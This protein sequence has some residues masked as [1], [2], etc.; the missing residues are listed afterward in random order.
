MMSYSLGRRQRTL[1]L[2][3]AIVACN[4]DDITGPVVPVPVAASELSG[5][6]TFSDS[7]SAKTV[8][9]E[10]VC[11]NR[12]VMTFTAGIDNTSADL[13]MVGTCRSPRGP[14]ALN[15]KLG[16][17]PVSIV[18]DSVG[19]TV[20][21]TTGLAESCAYSGRLT[22]GNALSARGTVSC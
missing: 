4:D 19:F 14:G 22:G 9:E 1:A 2:L 12:G 21:S 3:L 8:I 20:A 11:L 6:W 5:A 16:G 17:S 13:R 18:G 15:M 10:T 7:T